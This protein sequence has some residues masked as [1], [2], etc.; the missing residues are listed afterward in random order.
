MFLSAN[1]SAYHAGD[2]NRTGT[3]LLQ[4]DFK[5]CASASSATPAYH[6]QLWIRSLA[7]AIMGR[8]GF[9]PPKQFAADLQSVPFGHSGICPSW[10]KYKIILT[11]KNYTIACFAWQPYFLIFST[12]YFPQGQIFQIHLLWFLYNFQF[13]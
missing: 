13:P 8:G 2:R 11:R 6:I 7:F 12:T 4:Q 3:V 9:E 5:S 1:L 10:S